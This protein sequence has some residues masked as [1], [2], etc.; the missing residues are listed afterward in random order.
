MTLG[1]LLAT[2][3][4]A[5]YGMFAPAGTP[6]AVIA[7]LNREVERVLTTPELKEK[8]LNIGMEPAGGPPE[9]LTAK[10]KEESARVAKLV[11]TAGIRPE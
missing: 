3:S 6:R 7:L 5:I 2:A 10:M 1:P 9:A 8:F 11:R 4:I